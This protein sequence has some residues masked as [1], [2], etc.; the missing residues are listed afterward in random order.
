MA[1]ADDNV[2]GFLEQVLNNQ[3]QESIASFDLL[4]RGN[5][6]NT[7]SP[8][9][10]PTAPTPV[11]GVDNTQ[12]GSTTKTQALTLNM[13]AAD[14]PA[15]KTS[16]EQA[17]AFY[18]GLWS[19]NFPNGTYVAGANCDGAITTR[20]AI[21]VTITTTVPNTHLNM[22]TSNQN[23]LAAGGSALTTLTSHITSALSAAGVNVTVTVA[24]V[25]AAS[26]VTPTPTPTA[27]TTSGASQ[28]AILSVSAIAALVLALRH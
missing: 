16:I 5:A 7:T 10:S 11:P 25:A 3:V 28:T 19:G 23:T 21:V 26:T 4:R 13:A 9:S 17:Y 15:A 20:R 6:S 8:T 14:F 1:N 27:A 22:V 2:A 18:I 24:S 12:S